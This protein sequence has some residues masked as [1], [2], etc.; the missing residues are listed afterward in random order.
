MNYLLDVN[1]LMAWGWSDHLEHDRTAVWI[2]ATKKNKEM[3]V[4]SAIPQLG[5]IRVS[6]QRAAGQLT[7]NEAARTLAGMVK[8]L[9]EHHSFLADDRAAVEF[10][11]WCRGAARTT[12]AHLLKLAEAHSL[13]LSTL[14]ADIPGA[15]LIP[16]VT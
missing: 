10:P 12:D 14:D 2:A 6:V 11:E 5:F 9:G 1:V 13:R 16:A 4:T 7:V 15:F 3:L 8:A